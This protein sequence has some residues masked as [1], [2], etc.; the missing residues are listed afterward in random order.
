V[1][2]HLVVTGASVATYL[3]GAQSSG[4][5]TVVQWAIGANGSQASLGGMP[6]SAPILFPLGLQHAPK[7]ASAN[8]LMAPGQVMY[9]PKTPIVIES[10][11]YLHIIVR[12][13]VANATPGLSLRGDVEL[14][15]F[16][17]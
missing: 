8:E 14:D 12:L 1:G 10:Q 16:F 11:R 3:Q 15:G 4:A 9:V 7:S 6:A 2:F 17:F 5:A 13:P